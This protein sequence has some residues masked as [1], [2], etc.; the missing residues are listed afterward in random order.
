MKKV[1][2]IAIVL[3]LAAVIGV[4][5]GC[6]K[7][8]D[9]NPDGLS[10]CL[11]VDSSVTYQTMTGWGASS[12]WW[13]QTVPAGS[14]AQQALAETLY[15]ENGL[16]LT[17]YRYNIG[18][19]SA[20][21]GAEQGINY[22]QERKAYSLFDSS[23]YDE[24]KPLLDNFSDFTKY[25]ID[26][27]INAV[28]FLQQCL[29]QP[30]STVEKVVVF[31][32]SP[33]YLL[34]ANGKTH[35][36][37]EYDSNLP[38]ENYEA[39]AAY[40]I[41]C[42]RLLIANG[43]QVDTISPVNEPQHKWGGDGSTQEGCHYEPAEAAKVINTL[44]NAIEEYN[45]SST[46][47][48]DVTISA[49]ESG[50]YTSYDVKS[51]AVEYIYELSKY[52]CFTHLDGFSVHAYGEPM[53]NEARLSY[54]SRIANILPEGYVPQYDMTEVCHMEGGV[55]AGIDS[56][57][58]VAKMMD[59]DLQYL[60]ARSWSWWIAVS[61]YDYNDGLVYWDYF[62]PSADD[63]DKTVSTE[64]KYVKR[65]YAMMQYSKYVQTGDTRVDLQWLNA[66]S[67]YGDELSGTAFLRKDGTITIV[68]VNDS[69]KNY[70]VNIAGGYTDMTIATT[71]ANN[72]CAVTYDGAFKQSVVIGAN[73]VTTIVLK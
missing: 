14:A 49:V 65:Y 2:F 73:S 57:V 34:T 70:P 10:N 42:V 33:H 44:Y 54:V 19:G 37:N 26:K 11:A 53:S 68:L 29:K 25:S 1:K 51:R 30:G 41:N 32:N 13:S 15:S 52:P 22:V 69:T 39:F 24:S 31:V 18:G 36:T 62:F 56:A 59:K 9:L 40:V 48:L 72:D 16:G 27:D 6:G 66:S 43:I 4:A 67:A 61:D 64:I 5:A 20:E 7:T 46:A 28:S 58:Y 12:A 23:K 21:M 8:S 35:G 50:N 17:I 47:S 71:D 45:A 3:L 63:P 60:G 38:E 55:D